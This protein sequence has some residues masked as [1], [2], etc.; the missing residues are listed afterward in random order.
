MFDAKA[1]L[2]Q[3]ARTASQKMAA[4]PAGGGGLNDL[5]AQITAAAGGAAG[6]ASAGAGG[7]GAG[8]IADILAKVQ[9]TAG[10]ATGG[11]GGLGDTLT[12]VFAQATQGVKDASNDSGLSTA[13]RT[14]LGQLAGGQSPED[15]VAKLK[16]LV[17]NNQV[18][19]GALA[20][21]LGTL[22]VGTETGRDM[23][24]GVAKLGAGAL[25]GGLAYKAYQNYQSGK[26]LIGIDSGPVAAAPAGSG[27][28]PQAISNETAT[29]LIRAMIAAAAA[30][31]EIDATER[32]RILSAVEKAGASGEARAF[33][34]AEV[35]RPARAADLA[36]GVASQTEAI[37]IY[38]AARIA[39]DPDNAAE[40]AFLADL[41]SNLKLDK[42]LV[43]H[44]EAAAQSAT[45]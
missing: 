10:K 25:I 20:G 18:A 8:G 9:E 31:G 42:G 1:L 33:L 6:G 40:V 4:A 37:E 29:R 28:E 16:G 3:V 34:A 2:E 44:L 36:R 32:S 43:A 14:A 24:A 5:L 19:A 26:P 23:A 35:E 17:G 27:F 7:A 22:I 13:A 45:V 21:V 30:D 38:A 15:L 11:A 39:I 41:A 12:Q